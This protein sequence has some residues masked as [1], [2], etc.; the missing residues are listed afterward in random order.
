MGERFDA[1]EILGSA[2]ITQALDINIVPESELCQF[3]RAA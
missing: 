3:Y 1:V 2:P